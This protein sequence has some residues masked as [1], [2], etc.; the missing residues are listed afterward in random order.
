M[1]RWGGVKGK[2]FVLDLANPE[3]LRDTQ[4]TVSLET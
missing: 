1:V 4:H 2:S 3:C